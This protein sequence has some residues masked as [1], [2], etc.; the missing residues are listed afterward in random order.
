MV[1]SNLVCRIFKKRIRRT[2]KEEKREAA[3]RTQPKIAGARL[4]ELG[5]GKKKKQT[6]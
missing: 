4:S 5:H 2:L 3:L 1:T 6:I